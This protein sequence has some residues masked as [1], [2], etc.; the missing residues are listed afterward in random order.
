MASYEKICNGTFQKNLHFLIDSYVSI[1]Y[2]YTIKGSIW[3]ECIFN[4]R[5]HT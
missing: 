3:R 1:I 5:W 2:E 4:R